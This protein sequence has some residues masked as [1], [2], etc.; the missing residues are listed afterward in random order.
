MKRWAA[1]LLAV[2]SLANGTPVPDA[3]EIHALPPALRAQV[4]AGLQQQG[5]LPARERLDWLIRFVFGP[6]GLGLDYDDHRTRT[7]AEAVADRKANC[8]SFT[9]LFMALAQEAGLPARAQEYDQVLMLYPQGDLIYT[10]RHMNVRVRAGLRSY[11]VDIDRHALVARDAARPASPARVLAH[12]YN[13]RGMELMAAGE[14]AAARA[15]LDQALA[16]DPRYVPAWNNLGVLLLRS[17]DAAQAEAAYLSA[18][19][20]APEHV[21]TLFNLVGLYAQ[22]GDAPRQAVFQRR[23]QQ[24]Q[25]EDPAQQ[26]L[27][28]VERERQ[29]DHAGAIPHYRRALQH[30]GNVHQLHFHLARAYRLAGE[31]RRAAHALQRAWQLGDDAARAR[32]RALLD[33]LGY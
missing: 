2:T 6:Q 9:L 33:E 21:G 24:A 30:F 25:A 32:Y 14:L 12:Y 28:G 31:P 18:L 7:V 11:S 16:Q 29:G 22:G 23:L 13:N 19:A 5:A 15:H 1:A 3:Q 17:G 10:A 4:Q 26:F 8:V 20:L 27:L